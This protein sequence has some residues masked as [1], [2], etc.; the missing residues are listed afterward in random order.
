MLLLL[1]A[2]AELDPRTCA[3]V[4]ATISALCANERVTLRNE[5]FLQLLI[6]RCL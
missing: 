6:R 3:A 1:D 5:P 4:G 2:D